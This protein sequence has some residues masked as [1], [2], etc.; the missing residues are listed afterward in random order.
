MKSI[1]SNNSG[2]ESIVITMMS[3]SRRISSGQYSLDDGSGFTI[4]AAHSVISSNQ[5][6]HTATRGTLA[7]EDAFN[8]KIDRIR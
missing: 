3:D 6:H 2:N 8:L 1:T 5:L 7:P 4:L